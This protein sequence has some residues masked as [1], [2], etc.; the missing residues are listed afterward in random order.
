MSGGLF[1]ILESEI[2]FFSGTDLHY[3]FDI[4]YE[5]FTIT[6]LTCVKDSFC[7]FN[8]FLNR[9]EADNDFNLDLRKKIHFHLNTTVVSRSTFLYTAS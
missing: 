5:Y 9:Y 8:D 6:N 2:T 7:S 1:S 3:I 4:I